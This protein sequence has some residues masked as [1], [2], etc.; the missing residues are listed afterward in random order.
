MECA[1]DYFIILRVLSERMQMHVGVLL[2]FLDIHDMHFG[3]R[4]Y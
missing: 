2:Q 4:E 3:I 1:Y